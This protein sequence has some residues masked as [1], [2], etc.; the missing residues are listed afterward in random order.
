MTLSQTTLE[1]APLRVIEP[2]SAEEK[3][4][5]REWKY[6]LGAVAVLFAAYLLLQNGKW[7]SGPD[8]AFYISV[9]RNL[10]LGRGFIFNGAVVGR[11]PPIWPSILALGMKFSTSFWFLNLLPMI[12]LLGGAGF[13]YWILR[14]FTSARAAMGIV[15][16]S[17]I[18]FFTYTSAVQLRTEGMFCLVFAPAVLVAMQ[19]GEGK[20]ISWR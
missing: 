16:L 3:K 2:V 17:G 5:V 8:T 10:A 12:G 19:I 18:L 15:V 7:V 11:I 20:N 9:A 13:W 14:R 1:I 4:P 6:C